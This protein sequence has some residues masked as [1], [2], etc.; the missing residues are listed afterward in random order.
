MTLVAALEISLWFRVLLSA[1]TF[2]RKSWVLLVIY[3]AFLRA[4]FTQS[5][6]VQGAFQ[7]FV[8]QVDGQ[9]QNQNTPPAVRQGWE[10]VKGISRQ[11]VEATDLRKYLGGA[12]GQS[13]KK[14][15]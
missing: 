6:F 2:N 14:P 15:Q 3:S 11:A 12:Q 7:Q 4:R 9:V 10:T 8:A 13:M 5:Q 1:F